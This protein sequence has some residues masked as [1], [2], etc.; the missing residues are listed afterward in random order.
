MQDLGLKAFCSDNIKIG[1]YTDMCSEFCADPLSQ[2][3]LLSGW[4]G[5]VNVQ[6]L[7]LKT[8]G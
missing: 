7:G 8:Q 6:H 5:G 4:G 2:S 3:Q 1:S